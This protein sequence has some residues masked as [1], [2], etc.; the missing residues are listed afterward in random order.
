LLWQKA[1][2][3]PVQ[4]SPLYVDGVVL[5][6]TNAGNGTVYALDRST[7]GILWSFL[8]DQPY[9]MLSS[10]VVADGRVFTVADGGMVRAF[11]CRPPP[12][13]ATFTYAMLVVI[14]IVVAV[15]LAVIVYVVGRR[16]K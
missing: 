8:P 5:V 16:R 14:P 3:G 4:A 2:P 11:D 9:F 13:E 1:L 15:A 12:A 7:G 10:P 6:V